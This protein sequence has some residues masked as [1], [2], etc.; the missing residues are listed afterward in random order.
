MKSIWIDF[1]RFRKEEGVFQIGFGWFAGPYRRLEGLRVIAGFFAHDPRRK[2]FFFRQSVTVLRRHSLR[3]VGGRRA[4]TS[5]WSRVSQKHRLRGERGVLPLCGPI[6][7]W[8]LH[9][10]AGAST[11]VR[12]RR[13]LSKANTRRGKKERIRAG[14]PVPPARRG[15]RDFFLRMGNVRAGRIVSR[16]PHCRAES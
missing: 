12:S 3:S 10:Q 1:I 2:N 11:W 13:Q 14:K 5:S 6:G 9:H 15:I 16:S 8:E 7:S 4:R